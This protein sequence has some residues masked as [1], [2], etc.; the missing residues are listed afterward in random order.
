MVKRPPSEI[1]TVDQAAKLLKIGRVQAYAAVSRGEIP[2]L[3]I[4][5]RI[6]VLRLPLE[7]MLRGEAPTGQGGAP[8]QQASA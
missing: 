3:R 8:K 2:H 5:K 1:I 4:G 6:L 7:R